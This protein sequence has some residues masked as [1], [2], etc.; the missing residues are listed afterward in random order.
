MKKG[1]QFC[2]LLVLILGLLLP[3]TAFAADKAIGLQLN[4]RD[5]TFDDAVPV[6]EQDRVY[7]PFRAVFEALEAD[8]RYDKDTNTITAVKGNTTVQFEI[9][10][11]DVQVSTESNGL[12]KDETV[13]T[14]A[15][16]FVRNGRTYVPV[17]F[18]AQA[19][20]VTVGWDSLSQT[21]VMVDKA[22]LRAS[23]QGQYTLMD[24]SMA[25]NKTLTKQPLALQG[26]LKLD[27]Q[28]A[29][30]NGPDATMVPLTGQVKLDGIST[31]DA[32]SVNMA[33]QLDLSALQTAMEKAGDLADQDK[34]MMEQLKNFDIKVLVD[35]QSGKMYYKSALLDTLLSGTVPGAAKDAWYQMDLDQ[36]L[37]G[38][39]MSWSALMSVN[40]ASYEEQVA[41]MLDQLPMTSADG[42]KV[43]LQAIEQYK[44]KNFRKSGNDYISEMKTDADGSSTNT[45]ITI[46]TDGNKVIGFASEANVYMGTQPIMTVKSEQ[47]GMKASLLVRTQME[48]VMTMQLSGDMTYSSTAERPQTKPA[49]GE[50]VV[51]LTSMMTQQ[52]AA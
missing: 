31:A 13:T 42:C 5:V 12:P 14:D 19:L 25:Y 28:V 38:S 23:L 11:T 49:T 46:K 45:R 16:S 43:M 44:D 51:D 50:A 18:A 9:G 8:V 21:V 39:G 48:G 7:V 37:Q 15:A 1:K 22:A 6:M 47:T 40:N 41:V 30:G 2:L 20:G 24:Q 33:V 17:R 32:G 36:L 34:T 27:M 3:S 4:G 35:S 10:K 52:Q 29:D 26:T